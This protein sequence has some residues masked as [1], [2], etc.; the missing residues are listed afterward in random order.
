MLNHFLQRDTLDRMAGALRVDPTIIK[1]SD[2]G[3]RAKGGQGTVTLGIVQVP[4]QLKALFPFS[5]LKVAV[6]KLEW[7][8]EDTEKS[9][10]FFKVTTSSWLVSR[11]C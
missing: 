4:E 5:E 6:K 3:P 11:F 1:T 9:T 8:R 2:I 10:K 7:D